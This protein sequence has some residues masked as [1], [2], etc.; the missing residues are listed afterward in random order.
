MARATIASL[1][2]GITDTYISTNSRSYG[3][4][5]MRFGG[6]FEFL[7]PTSMSQDSSVDNS[8]LSH[9]VEWGQSNGVEFEYV[10]ILRPTTP[11]RQADVIKQALKT[12][13]KLGHR[14]TSMRSAHLAPE[15]PYKWFKRDENGFFNSLDGK[16]SASEVNLPRQGFDDVFIPN[17]YVDILKWKHIVDGSFLGDKMF[18][19]ETEFC[20]EVDSKEQLEMCQIIASQRQSRME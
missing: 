4:E 2:A 6:K 15:S 9:F 19:Y 7:R 18:V 14:A 5:A 10:V 16:M 13:L 11:F 8:Y 20:H 3:E 1:A 17:G 12:M